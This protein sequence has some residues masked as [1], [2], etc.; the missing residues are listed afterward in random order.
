MGKSANNWALTSFAAQEAEKG[1]TGS[2]GLELVTHLPG[3]AKQVLH[4]ILILVSRLFC[5][6]NVDKT[7]FE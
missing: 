1:L 4:V 2:Q 6:L 3:R 5:N 7:T